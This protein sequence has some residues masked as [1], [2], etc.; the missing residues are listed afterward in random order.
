MIRLLPE[1]VVNRIAA[2]EVVVRP[3]NAIKE[4]IENSIDAGAKEISISWD[5]LKR[6]K[7]SDDGCGIDQGDLHLLCQRFAT[8]KLQDFE[9]LTGISTFGFRG[10]ALASISQVSHLSVRTKRINSSEVWEAT[11]AAGILIQKKPEISSS[12]S[13][14]DLIF[15][16]LFFN[17]PIRKKSLNLVEEYKRVIDLVQKFA[18]HYPKIRFECRKW[19]S[20]VADIS[21]AGG[22]S[23]KQVIERIFGGIKGLTEFEYSDELFEISGF[24]A[25]DG[26]SWFQLFINGRLVDCSVINKAIEAVALEISPRPKI[27]SACK[28]WFVVLNMTVPAEGLDVN[29]HPTKKEV[30]FAEMSEISSRLKLELAKKLRETSRSLSIIRVFGPASNHSADKPTTQTLQSGKSVVRPSEKIRVDPNQQ[31]LF[32]K[33]SQPSWSQEFP[34]LTQEVADAGCEDR[35]AAEPIMTGFT[36]SLVDNQECS[37]MNME[38]NT[39]AVHPSFPPAPAGSIKKIPGSVFIGSIR[40]CALIQKGQSLIA[41]DVR[42][43]AQEIF[44]R[45]ILELSSD[46]PTRSTS[47]PSSLFYHSTNPISILPAIKAALE[48]ENSGASA[49]PLDQK[50]KLAESLANRLIN[51]PPLGIR[52][53]GQSPFDAVVVSLVL[54]SDKFESDKLEIGKGLIHAALD[55]EFGIS[56]WL[57]G[58]LSV[59]ALWNSRLDFSAVDGFEVARLSEL[60]KQFERC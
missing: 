20:G 29:V 18:V 11:Y 45:E 6:V 17:S 46:P 7:V 27:G 26:P 31:L 38:M 12:G 55:S 2:G 49:L 59:E 15:E 52:I 1:S 30:I 41:I 19:G 60:Y 9:G 36:A 3:V 57:A 44:Y 16:D 40:D 21:S 24:L 54:F 58:S 42:T 35:D 10:E 56:K 37:C 14:T 5:G 22:Q 13:F 43:A 51:R 28:G 47:S 33:S 8:S 23:P 25:V 32:P 50:T 4:L 34:A 39:E 53:G 48:N